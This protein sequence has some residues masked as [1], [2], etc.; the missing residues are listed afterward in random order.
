MRNVLADIVW[1]ACNDFIKHD[2]YIMLENYGIDDDLLGD[3]PSSPDDIDIDDDIVL[4][5]FPNSVLSRIGID[6]EQFE[7]DDDAYF[8]VEQ[9]VISAY[10]NAHI[11]DAWY[12]WHNDTGI[13]SDQ[14]ND[15]I[16]KMLCMPSLNTYAII[17][18]IVFAFEQGLQELLPTEDSPNEY[19][20]LEHLWWLW[21]KY[22]NSKVFGPNVA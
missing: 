10:S 12:N 19:L 7:F 18:F 8:E 20:K 13:T 21:V 4:R 14:L 17:D 1:C 2:A 15:L 3:G 11:F 22:A 5:A 9:A 6:A 16:A